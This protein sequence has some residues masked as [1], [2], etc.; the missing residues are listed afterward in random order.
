MLITNGGSW[1]V[2]GRI[3]VGLLDDGANSHNMQCLF[4]MAEDSGNVTV[5]SDFTLGWNFTDAAKHAT[6]TV[7]I[8]GGTLTVGGTLSINKNNTADDTCIMDIR[9]GT[10]VKTGADITATVATWVT[11]GKMT[12]YGGDPNYEISAVYS[13]GSTTIRAGRVTPELL[14]TWPDDNATD[15]STL[16]TLRAFFDE[17]IFKNIGNIIINNYTNEAPLETI[18][19]TDANVSISGNTLLINPSTTLSANTQVYV[20]L[21][22]GVVKD[23]DNNLCE[24]ITDKNAWNFTTGATPSGTTVG[25]WRFDNDGKTAGQTAGMVRDESGYGND[26]SGVSSP[27]YSS[28]VSG[29]PIPRTGVANTLSLDLEQSS[30]QYIVVSDANTLDFGDSSFTIEAYVK[31]ESVP[32]PNTSS[33]WL[34][35]KRGSAGDD[36]NTDYG[37]AF[38][39]PGTT[40]YGASE[41]GELILMRSN[42]GGNEVLAS[43]LATTELGVW[44]YVSVAFD[45]PANLV[46]FILNDQTSEKPQTYTA[47]TNGNDLWIG[48]KGGSAG[49]IDGL[50]DEVRI[51]NAFLPVE[52][53]L[54]ARP[55]GTVLILR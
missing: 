1:T 47:S 31:F 36:K 30:S 19:V 52:D 9:G 38:S 44:H 7:T 23:A 13:G 18:A 35:S 53:L 22:S 17:P 20:T 42:G 26:G 37:V 2:D 41:N 27:V 12:A 40:A 33:Q 49:G 21:D 11:D 39:G 34:L 10:V 51:S 55:R 25:Y 5:A 54:N 16:V 8:K 3:D 50:I 45:A 46:R 28:S 32:G 4:T 6:S 24:A 29:S 43:D 15:I 14:A 48:L